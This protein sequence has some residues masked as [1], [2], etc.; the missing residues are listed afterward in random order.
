MAVSRK[1]Q[2]SVDA[3]VLAAI[4]V[5]DNRESAALALFNANLSSRGEIAGRSVIA[6]FT[7]DDSGNLRGSATAEVATTI[8]QVIYFPSGNL[9]LHSW[10][11][12]SGQTMAFALVCNQLEINS[13]S[14]ITNTY[15]W[16]PFNQNEPIAL[17]G[18]STT[19]T[20]VVTTEKT[21]TLPGSLID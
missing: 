8:M 6:E 5:Q 12:D 14:G 10:S 7:T 20:E 1:L 13:W 19:T 21:E 3:A 17:P 2:S 11:A 4:H 18:T 9:K 15:A 16:T